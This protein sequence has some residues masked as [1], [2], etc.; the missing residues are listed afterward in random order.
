MGTELGLKIVPG[1]MEGG[2]ADLGSVGEGLGDAGLLGEHKYARWSP[3]VGGWGAGSTPIL[4]FNFSPSRRLIA[5]FK[6]WLMQ[7]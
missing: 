4:F 2:L 5:Y 6:K 1:G 3:G 7:A